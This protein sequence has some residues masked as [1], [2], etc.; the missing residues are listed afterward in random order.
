MHSQ[1]LDF[2]IRGIILKD[3]V[4]VAPG[5]AWCRLMPLPYIH[6]SQVQECV[7]LLG[8][9]EEAAWTPQMQ[10]LAE[11]VFPKGSSPVAPLSSQA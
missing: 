8:N 2:P 1:D 11:I 4:I 10:E 7:N 5:Y 9:L 3:V 6:A